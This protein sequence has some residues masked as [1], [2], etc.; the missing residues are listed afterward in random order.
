[1]AVLFYQIDLT[2]HFSAVVLYIQF[3]EYGDL[4]GG[5][6]ITFFHN[7]S[8]KTVNE[9][10]GEWSRLT[11]NINIDK[12]N[13][14]WYLDMENKGNT[15]ESVCAKPCDIGEFYIQG[16]LECCWLCR[17]CRDNEYQRC[18][19]HSL[20]NSIQFNSFRLRL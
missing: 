14:V 12:N 10:I 13:L 1:M 5:Y 2:S 19:I 16:E 3:D 7:K 4:V 18:A 15:P 17:R 20:F 8:G 9:K 6:D 11:N